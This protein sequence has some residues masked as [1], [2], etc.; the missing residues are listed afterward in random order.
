LVASGIPECIRATAAVPQIA[1]DLL[2]R[3][4]SAA[5]GHQPTQPQLCLSSDLVAK[6]GL[7]IVTARPNWLLGLAVRARYSLGPPQGMEKISIGPQ[8]FGRAHTQ[9]GY[10]SS[11]M[12]SGRVSCGSDCLAGRYYAVV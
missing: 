6:S 5:L 3:Q 4:V 7:Q 10:A 8:Y 12:I 9:D 1:A 11:L 2:Q